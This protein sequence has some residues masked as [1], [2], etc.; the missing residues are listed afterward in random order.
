MKI[1]T[2]INIFFNYQKI[3]VDQFGNR[4]YISKKKIYGRYKRMVLYNGVA[5]PSKIPP[6]WHA[7][8]HYVTDE[9]NNN[10]KYDWQK[11]PTPNLTGTK[12]AYFPEGYM[13]E[14]GQRK[15]VAADYES[16]QPNKL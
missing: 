13:G 16:W 12:N 2:I 8:M 15:N 7:W 4:Y 3:G 10:E 1:G 5:E 9:I 14:K 6:M 11:T